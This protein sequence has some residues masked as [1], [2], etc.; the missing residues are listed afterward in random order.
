LEIPRTLNLSVCA[1]LFWHCG[2]A[3]Y[4]LMIDDFRNFE[5]ETAGDERWRN[6]QWWRLKNC[7]NIPAALKANCERRFMMTSTFVASERAEN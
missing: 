2:Q 4:G 6:Y 5:L 7:Q 3:G 1:A